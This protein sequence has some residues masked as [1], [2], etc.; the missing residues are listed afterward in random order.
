MV[1]EINCL[2]SNPVEGHLGPTIWAFGSWGRV[3]RIQ[4]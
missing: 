2:S 1:M 4:V 3:G